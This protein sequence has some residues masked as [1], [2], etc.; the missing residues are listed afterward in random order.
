M[1][2]LAR[3]GARASNGMSLNAHLQFGETTY[4]PGRA[5]GERLRGNAIRRGRHIAPLLWGSATNAAHFGDRA[6]WCRCT[7]NRS[8]GNER[9]D[10]ERNRLQI[11]RALK[12]I[13]LGKLL[14]NPFVEMLNCVIYLTNI[15]I[16]M[17]N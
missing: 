8:T 1:R 11:L 10:G 12:Y 16:E 4:T 17:Q 2:R 13:Y 5:R 3:T 9:A 14:I 15:Y 6:A 7:W